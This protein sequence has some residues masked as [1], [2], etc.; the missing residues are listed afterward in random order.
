L[1]AIANHSGQ[2]LDG[3]DGVRVLDR[4]P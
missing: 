4:L 3:D 2:R 1:G